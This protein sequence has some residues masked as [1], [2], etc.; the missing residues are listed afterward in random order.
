MEAKLRVN[1]FCLRCC[2][3][4]AGLCGDI[5]LRN[6]SPYKR[7]LWSQIWNRC[8]QW[9]K[10]VAM[11]RETQ[12]IKEVNPKMSP[13]HPTPHGTCH[14]SGTN[15]SSSDNICTG[16]EAHENII[17]NVPPPPARFVIHSH[18]HVPHLHTSRTPLHHVLASAVVGG[19]SCTLV[20]G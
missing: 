9:A 10:N 7:F 16:L 19:R 15:P 2:R 4:L 6:P 11:G 14:G 12:E 20:P 1:R 3:P 17:P 5:T 18:K 8:L 13:I